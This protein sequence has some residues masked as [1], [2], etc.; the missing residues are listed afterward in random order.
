MKKVLET[1]TIGVIPPHKRHG[2]PS[3]LFAVWVGVNMLLLTAIT[4][5]LGTTV[6]NLPLVDAF[7]ALCIGCLVGGLA[8]A[9][10]SAQGPHLGVPQ[11]IQSR[12]QFG[13]YGSFIIT[14]L[15]VVI[16]MGWL[17]SNLVASGLA[18]S[19]LVPGMATWQGILLLTAANV[20]V[21]IFGYRAIHFMMKVG[22]ILVGL[23]FVWAIV[24]IFYGG[25]VTAATFSQGEFTIAGFTGT[26]T[27]AALWVVA[28]APY[29]SDYSRYLPQG[30]GNKPAFWA[31]YTGVVIGSML[32]MTF[33]ILVGSCIQ[34]ND[35]IS[36]I[37]LL[38]GPAGAYL[39]WSA[40]IT[41]SFSNAVNL[42]GA[43][44]CSITA[45]Q[46]FKEDFIP[47]AKARTW[48]AIVL[49]SIAF[50][51]GYAGH[52]NFLSMLMNVISLIFF[53]ITPWTAVNLVDYYLVKG[54]SYDVD[55]F[56]KRNGGIYGKW[57]MPA[58]IS[59][60]VGLA[61]QIPFLKTDLY[62][63]PMVALLDDT[64]V[65][66]IVGLVLTS[67]LYYLISSKPGLGASAS[68]SVSK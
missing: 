16:Y 37:S 24:M 5:G 30:T 63:G 41:T 21:V 33:G 50:V 4:G 6:F 2:K 35:I 7:V 40:T 43:V 42:Y 61:L 51:V 48:Y 47:G 68:Y 29:V 31:T 38:L 62:T 67:I 13:S 23:G 1:E 64:D 17:A 53:T 59:Y 3:D 60:F 56:F 55:S 36:G 18:F 26:V 65:S 49:G 20:L 10:H 58:L 19:N 45:V 12:G 9:L 25:H 27:A 57:S 52:D 22:A 46:T 66:W 14:V 32:P 39:L 28:F 11:M 44:L 8:M 15:V 54:G 34:G